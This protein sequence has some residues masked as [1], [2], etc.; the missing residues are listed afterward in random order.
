MKVGSIMKH[1]RR[2]QASAF[3]GFNEEDLGNLIKKLK[4][5]DLRYNPEH[6]AICCCIRFLDF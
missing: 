3:A 2:Q 4:N 5:S 1:N 6:Y